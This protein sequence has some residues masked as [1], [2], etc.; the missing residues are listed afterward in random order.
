MRL[1]ENQVNVIRVHEIPQ[2]A[3]IITSKINK[4]EK[5]SIVI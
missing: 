5:T 3:V 4:N 1:T 2:L